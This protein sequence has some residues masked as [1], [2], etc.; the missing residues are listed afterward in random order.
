MSYVAT[1]RMYIFMYLHTYIR[2][3]ICMYVG[4]VRVNAVYPSHEIFRG[5]FQTATRCNIPHF[6]NPFSCCYQSN[7]YFFSKPILG[8]FHPV[9]LFTHFSK[10][11]MGQLP[12]Y[13]IGRLIVFKQQQQQIID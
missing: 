8:I 11:T 3:Y 2:T 13:Q 12:V 5:G 6:D 7:N 9:T 10:M 4:I 1:V